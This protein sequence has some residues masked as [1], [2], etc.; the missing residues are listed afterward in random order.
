[1]ADQT[2]VQTIRVAE[3]AQIQENGSVVRVI[4]TEFKVGEH[5]P[6]IVEIPAREFTAALVK[7]KIE[8]IAREV[9]Q[10]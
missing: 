2:E 4:R 3:F 1:M 7:Q 9:R 6:F 10:L 8:I 5:G